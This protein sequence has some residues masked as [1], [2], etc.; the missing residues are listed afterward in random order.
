MS[1][2]QAGSALIRRCLRVMEIDLDLLN[3]WRYGGDQCS[4]GRFPEWP[5]YLVSWVTLMT[6]TSRTGSSPTTPRGAGQTAPPRSLLQGKS[7]PELFTAAVLDHLRQHRA[8]HLRRPVTIPTRSRR[9]SSKSGSSSAPAFYLPSTRRRLIQGGSPNDRC[10]RSRCRSSNAPPTM[11]WEELTS[12]PLEIP[13][14]P[15][16]TYFKP[17]STSTTR[18]ALAVQLRC[19]HRRGALELHPERRIS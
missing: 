3:S 11:G 6:R 1:N 17:W 8:G 18:P 15:P 12:E 16:V 2:D 4:R 14:P 10:S 9:C 7:R 13:G 5:E 19:L